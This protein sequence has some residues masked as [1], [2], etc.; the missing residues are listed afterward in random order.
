[1]KHFFSDSN[2]WGLFWLRFFQ[3]LSITVVRNNAPTLSPLITGTRLESL[4]IKGKV[5][6]NWH[7]LVTHSNESCSRWGQ[8]RQ[9]NGGQED[10]EAVDGRNHNTAQLTI[11]LSHKKNW[12]SGREQR[13]VARNQKYE[14]AATKKKWKKQLTELAGFWH[15][16]VVGFFL[17]RMFCMLT[18][19]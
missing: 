7:S 6:R 19:Y 16:S 9:S 15:F 1:M 13:R 12:L 10:G 5:P 2:P 11:D 17:V 18:F 14:Q 8:V 4:E 3:E